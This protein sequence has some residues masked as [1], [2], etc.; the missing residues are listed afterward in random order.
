MKAG[1]CPHESE[2]QLSSQR[3]LGAGRLFTLMRVVSL[4]LEQGSLLAVLDRIKDRHLN[5][6]GSLVSEVI[7]SVSPD[8]ASEVHVLDHHGD[9]SCVNGAEVRVLKHASDEGLS[10]LLERGEGLRVVAVLANLGGDLADDALEG[11]PLDDELCR[12]LVALYLSDGN[13][14]R[15]KPALYLDAA[16]GRSSLLGAAGRKK[17]KRLSILRLLLRRDVSL[18]LLSVDLLGGLYN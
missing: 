14:A 11:R 18:L 12:L 8:P 6:F 10:G 5:W 3:S 17:E 2:L 13:G 1:E 7:E 15:A 16:N 9:S 4:P